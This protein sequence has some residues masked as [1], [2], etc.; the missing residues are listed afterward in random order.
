LDERREFISA[1]LMARELPSA[2]LK[3]TLVAVSAVMRP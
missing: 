1:R 3:M 2:D